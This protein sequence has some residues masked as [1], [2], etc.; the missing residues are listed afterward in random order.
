MKQNSL[1]SD[2]AMRDKW[3]N[4]RSSAIFPI[5]IRENTDLRI[6]A[7]DYWKIKNNI[8]DV[9]VVYRMYNQK[10]ELVNT[11]SYKIINEHNDFSVKEILGSDDFD[12]MIEVEYNSS[13]NVKFAFPGITAIYEANGC[14]SAVHSA[15]RVKNSHEAYTKSTS[16]ETN[17]LCKFNDGITPFFHIFN[18]QENLEQP[19]TI[20]IELRN[21][22]NEIIKSIKHQTKCSNAFS[23]QIIFIDDIFDTSNLGNDI[24]CIVTLVSNSVFPRLV[25]GNYHKSKEFLEVTHSFP[26]VQNKDYISPPIKDNCI[27][28]LMACVKPK[29]MQCLLTSFPTNIKAQM[30][31]QVSIKS[32]HNTENKVIDWNSGDNA[33]EIKLE[34]EQDEILTVGLAEDNIPSRL[35]TSFRYSIKNTNSLYSTDIASGAKSWVYPASYNHWGY[36]L[37]SKEFDT[38]VLMTNVPHCADDITNASGVL[39]IFFN[40]NNKKYHIKKDIQINGNSYLIVYISDI[41]TDIDWGVGAIHSLSWYLE[42]QNKNIYTDWLSFTKD[43]RICGDHG[44]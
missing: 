22:N 29:N 27:H 17:W 5:H 36:G 14:V 1:S 7:F 20:Q 37:M 15:G 9:S 11:V 34:D 44:F 3:Q 35:N 2:F 28:S 12:G 32:K 26:L 16:K 39:N 30:K 41:L 10:G 25:C 38:V 24:F 40:L 19:L 43:G 33:L 21:F 6:L 8:D 18:G 13:S 31:A 42:M 4:H 23:S